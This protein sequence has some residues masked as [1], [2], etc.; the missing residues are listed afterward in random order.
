MRKYFLIAL[1]TFANLTANAQS[2]GIRIGYIDMEYILEKAPEYAEAKNQL[3]LKAQTWKQEIEVK[4]NEINKLKESL[5]TEKVLLTKELISEREDEI[6]FLEN[7]MLDYQQKRFGPQGDLMT[8]KTMLVKPIQDQVFNAVQ[9]IAEAKKYDFVFDKASD[10]TML[11]AAQRFD[12]SDQVLRVLTRS[13]K[14]EQMNK[15]Q[16]KELEAQERKE[17]MDSANPDQVERQKKIDERKAARDKIIADRKA[18]LEAKKQEQLEKRQQLLDERKANK[19]QPKAEGEENTA[20][21]AQQDAKARLA[22]ER[23]QKLDE[24]KAAL[25]AKKKEQADRRQQILDER[26]ANKAQPKAP[27][28]PKEGEK[29]V[30]AAQTPLSE[31]PKSDVKTEQQDAKDKLAQER[32]QKLDERKK[33]LEDRKKKILEDREKAKKDRE[34]KL[35]NKSSEN[36]SEN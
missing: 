29:Q 13:Q 35:K 21:K 1:V 19:A 16:L 8:Q 17:D 28:T 14:K 25:E 36:K 5:K 2:R 26:N 34:E 11:F 7:E 23:Q 27:A 18:A 9:D 3:E 22:E 6:R 4:K 12:I 15:K 31:E 32:Q 10:L 20:P 30:P 33:A 24:R